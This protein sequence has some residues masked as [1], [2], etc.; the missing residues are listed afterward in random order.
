MNHHLLTYTTWVKLYMHAT[1]ELRTVQVPNKLWRKLSP[2]QV[3]VK[4]P[5][6]INA[7]ILYEDK[8]LSNS[9]RPQLPGW[10]ARFAH[11]APVYPPAVA[12]VLTS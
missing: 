1:A 6:S 10:C 4:V 9:Y 8:D 11:T 12:N 5:L 3:V 2:V 7:C